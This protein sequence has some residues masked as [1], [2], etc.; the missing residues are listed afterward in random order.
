MV[1]YVMLSIYNAV[2]CVGAVSFVDKRLVSR[3][4]VL[5]VNR[6]NICRDLYDV[7]QITLPR[8]HF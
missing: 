6:T 8:A 1:S 7:S 2:E 5:R 3:I 4:F